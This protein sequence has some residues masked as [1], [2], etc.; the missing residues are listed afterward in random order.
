MLLNRESDP[1]DDSKIT[2]ELLKQNPIWRESLKTRDS[3]AK[4]TKNYDSI[5]VGDRTY[6]SQKS[7]KEKIFYNHQVIK[8]Y[9]QQF[10]LAYYY[11]D[12][13][14]N[15]DD[16]TQKP[17]YVFNTSSNLHANIFSAIFL[18]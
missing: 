15:T 1:D 18:L 2:Q 8:N 17:F 10:P 12:T 14:Q 16:L 9:N 11:I 4:W 3:D 5:A 13:N 7:K 6:F